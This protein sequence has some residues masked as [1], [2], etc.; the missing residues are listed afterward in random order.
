MRA[1]CDHG[2][3]VFIWLGERTEDGRYVWVHDTTGPGARGVLTVC[4]RMTP[5]TAVEAGEACAACGHDKGE[6]GHLWPEGRHVGEYPSP[7]ACACG[8]PAWIQPPPSPGALV[9]VIDE[10]DAERRRR[11]CAGESVP[12]GPGACARDGCGHLIG[13]HRDRAGRHKG[14]P[15][16][17]CRCPGWTGQPGA[18]MPPQPPVQ[19]SLPGLETIA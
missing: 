10:E 3:G 18:E 4:D 5:A 8:C 1:T 16:H 9:S 12:G 7:L 13:W 2:R 19:D 17:Q 6:G 15:C 14:R 11:L